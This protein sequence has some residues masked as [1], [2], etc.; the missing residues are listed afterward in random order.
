[1]NFSI[2]IRHSP[3]IQVY[4]QTKEMDSLPSYYSNGI[5]AKPPSAPKL[6]VQN[7]DGSIS[8]LI[9]FTKNLSKA[10]KLK[11]ESYLAL[12]YGI[13]L[14]EPEGNVLNSAGEI[15]WNGVKITASII[16]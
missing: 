7:L 6:P 9:A 3:K 5:S 4:E 15:L 11:I 8:E 1:M 2:C 16:M 10:E 12:K 14:S 13:T